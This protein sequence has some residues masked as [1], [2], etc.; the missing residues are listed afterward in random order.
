MKVQ[1]NDHAPEKGKVVEN[2]EA[3]IEHGQFWLQNDEQRR[4]W[5]TLSVNES[6][7][8]RLETFG[9]L[10]DPREESAH[11]IVGLIASGQRSVTLIDCI[12]INTQNWMRAR[13]GE[14]DWSHQTSLVNKVVDGIGFERGEEIAFEQAVMEIST[15]SKWAVPELVKVNL[16][17][18]D[19]NTLTMNI[20]KAAREDENTRV[21]FRGEEV[22]VCVRFQPKGGVQHEGAITR[23]QVE[24]HCQ[25]IIERADGSLMPLDSILSFAGVMLDLLSICCNETPKVDSFTLYRE[26]TKPHPVKLHVRMRG[27]SVEGREGFPHAALRLEDLGGMEGVARWFAVTERYGTAVTLLTSNW[28]NEKAY[29]EDNLSRMYTA[30]EGLLSRKKKRNSSRMSSDELAQFA[31][32]AIPGFSSLISRPTKEWALKVREVRDQKL[33]HSDPNSTLVIG[34]RTM[35]VMTNLLYVVGSSFLLREMGMEDPQINEYIKWTYQTLPLRE[36]R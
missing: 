32:E 16:G 15:L 12:P 31:E 33:S 36:Q 7:E 22:K 6:N 24:D 9:S 28:Y 30:V 25:L 35:N 8:A 21:S 1:A 10:M 3:M 14:T 29:T 19:N 27:Y 20:S 13:H 17:E 26:E 5:G 11:T 4:L 18:S 34:F 2:R 23:Y